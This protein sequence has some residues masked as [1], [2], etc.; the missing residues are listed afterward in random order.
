[1][2]IAAITVRQ[3]ALG[4]FSSTGE[5]ALICGIRQYLTFCIYMDT[6]SSMMYLVQQTEA[7]VKWRNG[8][9]DLK[10]KVAIARRM[11]RISAGLFGD[12]K[13]VGDGV[14]ELRIDTGPGYRLYF[15]T[16]DR[17]VIILLVGGDKKTQAAD[18]KLA[19]KLAGEV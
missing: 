18:I 12:V 15:T 4:V 9:R 5:F 16:R 11:E 7:F 2:K 14:S 17:V 13:S 6:N 10:A 19:H 3:A 8:L 1:M